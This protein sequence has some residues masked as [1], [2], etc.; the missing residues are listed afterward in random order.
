M[1]YHLLRTS[2][3]ILALCL[4]LTTASFAA[5]PDAYDIPQD[6]S[7]DALVFAVENDILR[8]DHMGDLLPDKNIT[9]GEMAAVLVRLLGATI[10]GDI[11]AF[12]D[13]PADAWYVKELSI[14]VAA[15]IMTGESPQRMNP[16]GYITRE[17]AATVLCRSFAIASEGRE[18]YC[19]FT[20]SAEIAAFA[21]DHVSALK[22]FGILLGYE[23]GSFRP[24]AYI[25]RAEVAQLIYKAIDCIADTPEELPKSGRVLYRGTA[26]LPDTLHL[27]GTLIIS[28]SAPSTFAPADWNI[29]QSLVLRTGENTSADLGNVKTATLICSPLSGN[30]TSVQDKVFLLG[31]GIAYTGDAETLIAV[32]G[33]HHFAGNASKLELRSGA[34]SVQGDCSSVIM[35]GS[36]S[37][38]LNGNCEAITVQGAYGHLTAN[39]AI[40]EISICGAHAVLDGSGYAQTIHLYDRDTAITL[41][42]AV[43]DDA[44]QAQHD[45]ALSIVQ[46]MKVPCTIRSSTSLYRNQNMTGWI[47]NLPAGTTVYNQWNPS[48]SG[49][50]VSLED[51]TWGWVYRETCKI[52]YDAPS[53]DG[54]LDYPDAVKEGFVDLRGY[55]SETQYLVWVSRY[56]QKVI[57]YQGEKGNWDVIRTFPCSS[58]KNS[59]I[60]PEGIFKIYRHS[61]RWNFDEY[62]VTTISIF[63]GDH[64]FHTVTYNYDGSFNDSRVGIPLS[65]GCIRMLPE[66]CRY[67]QE[68]PLGTTVIIY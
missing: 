2:A 42:Y 5:D 66:D 12:Q 29:S 46:T 15:G 13:I 54:D 44:Y 62:Y 31:G 67:I 49:I 57:V 22:E 45:D 1:K 24:K 4:L 14:A 56:T 68:L 27:D 41:S 50:L 51:G 38:T 32:G 40:S 36:T 3:L 59:T 26:A 23:D 9:R 39:G 52:S 43:L 61:N 34:L 17:Q 20:D 30:V 35:D 6:W 58:G 33:A 60:T 16:E 8:G 21:Q 55:E 25:T 53:T 11:S 63:N 7:H 28:T 37:L 18:G 65:H 47:C 10:E 19:S 48:G 64:A